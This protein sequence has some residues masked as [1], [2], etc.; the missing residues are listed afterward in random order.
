M[1]NLGLAAAFTLAKAGHR[2]TVFEATD[3]RN[4]VELVI[5]FAH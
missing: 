5:I 2:V 1:I 4:K 3:G